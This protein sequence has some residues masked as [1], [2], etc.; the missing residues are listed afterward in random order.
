[1]QGRCLQQWSCCGALVLSTCFGPNSGLDMASPR[2]CN[3]K[4][5]PWRSLERGI[6]KDRTA[7]R[8]DIPGFQRVAGSS[9]K[10]QMLLMCVQMCLTMTLYHILCAQQVTKPTKISGCKFDGCMVPQINEAWGSQC[11]CPRGGQG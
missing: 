5:H 4:I 9:G 6:L 10:I 8:I 2:D 7:S 11:Q 1:M 3:A